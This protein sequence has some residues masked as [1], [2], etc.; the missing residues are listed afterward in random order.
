[1][2]P[3]PDD[4]SFQQLKNSVDTFNSILKAIEV[5]IESFIRCPRTSYKNEI[6]RKAKKVTAPFLKIIQSNLVITNL[7]I[8]NLVITIL[9]I[10]NSSL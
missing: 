3:L 10:T 1:M 4:T 2:A 8:T 7:V 5:N 9:I 6:I